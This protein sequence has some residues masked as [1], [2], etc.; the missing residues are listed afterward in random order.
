MALFRS[1]T[2]CSLTAVADEW[3]GAYAFY[4]TWSESRATRSLD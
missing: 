2:W 1:T 4:F 3:L